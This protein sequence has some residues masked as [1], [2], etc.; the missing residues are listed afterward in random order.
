MAFGQFDG[1][2]AHGDAA[3]HA[4]IG[5]AEA[6]GHAAARYDEKLL[7]AVRRERLHEL[8]ALADIERA[9]AVF[10]DIAQLAL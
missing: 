6:D 8:V 5:F 2:H 4:H 7:A 1:L 3:H 10:A 9:D